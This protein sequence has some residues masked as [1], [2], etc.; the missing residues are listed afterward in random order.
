MRPVAD[1]ASANAVG[2]WENGPSTPEKSAKMHL[3]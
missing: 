1:G 2:H 3:F